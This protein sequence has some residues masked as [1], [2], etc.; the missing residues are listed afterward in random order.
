MLNRFSVKQRMYLIISSTFLLFI[1]MAVFAIRNGAKSR[2]MGI[3]KAGQVML[4]DQKARIQLASHTLALAIGH[5]LEDVQDK[6]ARIEIIRK[7]VD[8]IRYEEDK[9]GYYFVYEGTVNVANPPKKEIQGKDLVDTK[10]KDNV[11]VIRDLRD[12]AK[13][14]GG[15]VHYIWPKPGA[16]DTPK[17]S[18]SEMIPG[19]EIWIGTGAYLDNIDK[20]KEKMNQEISS[21]ARTNII[22]ML[23]I[24]GLIFVGIITLCLVIVLGISRSLRIMVTNF[25]DI[26]EGEGDL[27][28]RI[29]I[30]SKDEIAELARWF[31]VFIE[32]LQGI[33]FTIAQN[34]SSV[35]LESRTL[36][37]IAERLAGNAGQASAR[38]ENVAV[39]A[40]E[41]SANMN[42]VAAA[43]EQSTT[44]TTMVASAAEEMSSTISGIAQNA[45]KARSVSEK[46]V[47]QAEKTVE[48]MAELNSSADAISKVTETITQISEK[49]NLLALNATIEAARAGEAGKGFAV[50]ANEIKELASQTTMATK[51]IKKQ[52]DDVQRTT[53]STVQEIKEIASI[54]NGVNEIVSDISTAVGEQSTATQEIANSINQAATGLSEVNKNVNQVSVVAGTITKDIAKVSTA[55]DE[56]SESSKDVSSTSADLLRMA[57]ELKQVVGSFKI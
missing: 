47:E 9:S 32:K 14:G 56:I 5:A 40:E 13:E 6:N 48:R 12:R 22:N 19:T 34:T 1:V 4:D 27:T 54:I 16:D 10:D 23:V 44:N 38:S 57:N 3:D 45:E 39:A 33:I 25:Q 49:T 41:M 43:M 31:N 15:F 51:D 21:Q 35:D 20:Y 52:I 36:S 30:K 53:T 17:L 42:N 37:A 18:Y 55:A 7:M 2:D 46:A 29:T 24:A 8:D 50:V 28:K 11:Y 26:A